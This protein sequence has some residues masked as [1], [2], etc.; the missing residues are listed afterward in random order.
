M[1]VPKQ[2]VTGTHVEADLRQ[3]V[4]LET[5]EEYTMFP[6][7][8]WVHAGTSHSH[9]TMS[10]FYSPTDDASE[11]SVPGLHIVVGSIDHKKMEYE[12]IASIVLQKNRKSVDLFDVVDTEPVKDVPFHDKVLDYISVVIETNKN[13]FKRT[14]SS[15][16]S[17]GAHWT[18]I[19]TT[20]NIPIEDDD[21]K[22]GG[23]YRFLDR[24]NSDLFD[25][26]PT[27]INI[28]SLPDNVRKS[29]AKE[30]AFDEILFRLEADNDKMDEQ[31]LRDLEQH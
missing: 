9:N 24:N 15:Y 6:P 30:E 20:T 23:F 22:L 31:I 11:L 14:E 3:S 7:L 19:P 17:S 2:I 1:V 21:G 16:V 29:L 25:G 8:G 26:V 5:G 13:L 27:E 10:A 28:S 18:S 4:D 12:Y